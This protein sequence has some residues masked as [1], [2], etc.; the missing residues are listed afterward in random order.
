MG[1]RH[2]TSAMFDRDVE[3]HEVLIMIALGHGLRGSK[4]ELA[5]LSKDIIQNVLAPEIEK[6]YWKSREAIGLLTP[7]ALG[8]GLGQR[9]PEKMISQN[10]F[11]MQA[12][13]SRPKEGSVPF[14]LIS[15]T[16]KISSFIASRYADLIADI[17]GKDLHRSQNAGNSFVCGRIQATEKFCNPEREERNE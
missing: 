8:P 2:A 6:C 14:S 16:S 5:L 12:L 1:K 13:P 11:C 9:I 7:T 17:H 15:S 4:S 10:G 3:L